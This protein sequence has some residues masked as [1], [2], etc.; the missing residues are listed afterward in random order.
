MKNFKL[1]PRCHQLN[2]SLTSSELTDINRRAE[3]LGMRP[4]HFARITLLNNDA[5][6]AYPTAE[7]VALRHIRL[8]LSRLG[9]NLNQMVRRLNEFRKPLPEDLEPLLS[10]IRA[11]IGRVPQ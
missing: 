5:T 7:S 2:I 8:E 1:D 4:V 10:D 6:G 3:A 9:N 11:M